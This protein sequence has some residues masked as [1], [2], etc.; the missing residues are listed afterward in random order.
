[1][2]RRHFFVLFAFAV[3]SW[4]SASQGMADTPPVADLVLYRG[5]VVTVDKAFAIHE[6]VA[7]K[8]G[9]VLLTGTNEAV[10]KFKGDQTA[11]V[12]LQGRTVLPGLM[13][14]HSHPTG[15]AMYEFDH[16]IPMMES[17]ADVLAYVK[18]RTQVLDEGEW[19]FV[20]QVFITRLKERRYPTRAELDGVAPKHAVMFRTG[21]DGMLNSLALKKSGIDRDFKI[22]DGGTGFIEKDEQGEPT[23]ILRS[24]TRLAKYQSPKGGKSAGEQDRY[25]RLRDLFTDYNAVGI[26][27]IADRDCGGLG[28]Y[29]KLLENK[30]LTIRIAASRSLGTGGDVEGVK[31]NIRKIAAEPRGPKAAGDKAGT[32]MLRIVGTKSY[33]DGGMLTGSAFM[34]Q[35]WGKSKIYSITDPAYQ[36]L[37]FIPQEKL[38]PIVREAIENG[39]QFTAHSVGDGAVHALIEAYEEAAKALSPE[40][41]AKVRPCITHCN[42]MSAE[43]VERMAKLGIVADIQPVWLYLDA[44]TLNEQFGYDRLRYFQPLKSLF[45]KGVTVGG[46]SD[47][48]QKIGSLRSVNPYNPWL[49]M[50]TTIARRPRNYQGQ[51]HAEESLSREQAIRFYTINNARIMFLDGVAGSLEKGKLADMIVLDRDVLTCKEEEVKDTQVVRTYLEGKLV[52]EKTE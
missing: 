14:S 20:S 28:L 39:L 10:L 42:F 13:D 45:E 49:G 51:F 26:T 25:R 36:G 43:A 17:I 31:A 4:F 48:M 5:K 32:D 1:M 3:L 33:L 27:A 30:E 34:R 50:W 40:A 7:V 15:A 11:V 8:D 2:D 52:H 29:E 21:P 12:D 9:R 35:P 23:G 38:V 46:G 19:V 41:V 16:E 18:K 44:A 47:H 24:C 22:T 37:R 6:A